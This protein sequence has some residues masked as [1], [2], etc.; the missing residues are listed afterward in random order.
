MFTRVN[1]CYKHLLSSHVVTTFLILSFQIIFFPLPLL[2]VQLSGKWFI[3]IAIDII[4]CAIIQSEFVCDLSHSRSLTDG[5]IFVPVT[6]KLAV[7]ARVTRIGCLFSAHC[8]PV[9]RCFYSSFPSNAT[10]GYQNF[11]FFMSIDWKW[12]EIKL[13]THRSEA[14]SDLVMIQT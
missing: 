13:L 14:K 5:G 9:I 8:L 10:H 4:L 6:V 11:I 12:W 2:K 7:T 1:H 3:V